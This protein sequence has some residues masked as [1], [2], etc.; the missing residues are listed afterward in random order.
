MPDYTIENK[1]KEMEQGVDA[2]WEQ[3][4]KLAR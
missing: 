2:Q 3:A 4:W 1:V